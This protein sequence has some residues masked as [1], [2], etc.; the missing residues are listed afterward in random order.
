ML[1]PNILYW[2]RIIAYLA[3]WA[4]SLGLVVLF[5]FIWIKGRVIA[6]EPNLYI[7]AGE[8]ILSFALFILATLLIIHTAIRTKRKRKI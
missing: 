7:L 6:I 2:A 5:S 8:I 1:S 3:L 4:I